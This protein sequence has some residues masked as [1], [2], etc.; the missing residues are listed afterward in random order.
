MSIVFDR[1]WKVAIGVCSAWP[2]SRTSWI[3]GPRQTEQESHS[4][5]PACSL[6]SRF[7]SSLKSR[8]YYI[9]VLTH[10]TAAWRRARPTGDCNGL[11]LQPAGSH[12]NMYNT[13]IHTY[14]DATGLQL[15]KYETQDPPQAPDSR[16]TRT[17]SPNGS[18]T[19]RS[20]GTQVYTLPYTAKRKTAHK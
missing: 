20:R 12:R 14:V 4:V 5:Y 16:L 2:V 7:A 3:T 8:P 9:R 13:R 19:E 15:Q 11:R 18:I 10:A 17:T 6:S 1:R